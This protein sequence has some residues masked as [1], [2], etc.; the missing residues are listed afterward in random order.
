MRARLRLLLPLPFLVGMAMVLT[1][2]WQNDADFAFGH[3]AAVDAV[4]VDRGP[5]H[6]SRGR[7]RFFPTFRLADGQSLTLERAMVATELPPAGQAVQ[8]QCSTRVPAN[9]RMPANPGMDWVFCGAAGVWSLLTLGITWAMW[10]PPWRTA[11]ATRIQS[12]R[13]NTP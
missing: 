11:R 9:C 13:R 1:A 8:L 12:L 5:P 7:P 3:A 2:F 10:G 4:L 6:P